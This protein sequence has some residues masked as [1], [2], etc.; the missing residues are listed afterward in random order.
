MSCAAA[1][2]PEGG[3]SKSSGSSR[4]CSRFS[5]PPWGCGSAST[6]F[7]GRPGSAPASGGG[8]AGARSAAAASFDGWRLS[9][10]RFHA[11]SAASGSI[12]PF[13]SEILPRL[14]ALLTA[15]WLT[16]LLAAYWRMETRVGERGGVMVGAAGNG[17]ETTGNPVLGCET[18]VLAQCDNP[19]AGSASEGPKNGGSP[20]GGAVARAQVLYFATLRAAPA[21]PGVRLCVGF[22]PRKTC[23]SRG[24]ISSGCTEPRAPIIRTARRRPGAHDRRRPSPWLTSSPPAWPR[25]PAR[26]V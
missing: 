18:G 11:A 26:P 25:A 2:E 21:W 23:K 24:S 1:S 22:A 4:A 3:A 7:R 8:S 12:W 5:Q 17:V 9:L 19:R 20:A 15:V 13:T 6:V 14:T 10:L 16:P